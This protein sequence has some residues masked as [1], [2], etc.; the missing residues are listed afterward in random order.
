MRGGKNMEWYSA[1]NPPF[2][3]GDYLVFCKAEYCTTLHYSATH[4]AWN[5]W[6]SDD[7]ETIERNQIKVLAWTDAITAKDVLLG[8]IGK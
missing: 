6:D 8:L 3:S 7:E 5:V 1:K 4:D 2:K